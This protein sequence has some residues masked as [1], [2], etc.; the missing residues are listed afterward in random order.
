MNRLLKHTAVIGFFTLASRILG[1][2]RDALIAM[3]F[4]ATHYSDAF[5]IAFRPF[6]L[7]RKLFSEG[8]LSTSFVPVFS[9]IYFKENKKEAICLLYSLV[10]LLSMVC[11]MLVCIGLV[12]TPGIITVIA[13]GFAAGTESFVL[14]GFLFK[15]MLPYI[16]CILMLA[17]SMGVLNTLG[18]FGAPALAPVL[19]NLVIIGFTLWVCNHFTIPVTGLAL[20]VTV[21]GV[22]QLSLQIPYMIKTQMLNPAYFRIYHPAVKRILS[23]MLPT[24]IGA[25]AYQINIVVASFYASTLSPGSVSSLYYADRLVQFPLALFAISAATVFLP[26]LSK[27]VH[28]GRIDDIG[29]V[30]T[31]GVS[32]VFFIIIPAMAGMMAL[33]REIVSVLFEQGMFD[34]TA[35]ERTSICLFYLIIGLLGFAGTRLFVTIFYALDNVK[36]PFLCGLFSIFINT[37]GCYWVVDRFDVLGLSLMVSVS[38]CLGLVFLL[39]NIP[40]QVS[41][42][43]KDLLISA[44]RN[45]LLSGIMFCFVKV[46]ALFYFNPDQSKGVQGI[47]LAAIIVLGIIIYGMG[48]VLV[49]S[50]ESQLLKKKLAGKRYDKK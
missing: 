15:I 1:V 20:G 9:K 14:S 42:P 28:T 23:I 7:A 37:A 43:K 10:T 24:M 32:L 11:V 29:P 33:N 47:G 31:Q 41:I 30:F 13:P 2:V 35:V 5:F 25:A 50:P 12:F 4:G 38:G 46:A 49:S 3:A 48:H 39:F 27:K 8:T 36:T 34:Q 26:D 19:F 45:F 22:I 40:P 18:H 44:C 16:W 17:V 6:D 21:G